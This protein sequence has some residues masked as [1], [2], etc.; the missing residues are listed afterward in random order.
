MSK[1]IKKD[2]PIAPDQALS[3]A[4]AFVTKHK[5]AFIIAILAIF[6][7]VGFNAFNEDATEKKE[8]TEAEA[9]IA[10]I[11]ATWQSMQPQAALDSFLEIIDLYNGTNAA[12]KAHFYAGIIYSQQENYEEAINHLSKYNGSD[13]IIAPKAK[14]LLGNCYSQIEDYDNAIRLILEAA[15][16]ANNVAVTPACWRDVAAMYEAQGKNDKAMNL[17]KKIKDEYP[18]SPVAN[19][20]KVKLNA[21]K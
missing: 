9:A 5:K 3:K 21:A 8:N 16:L 10:N 15:S 17:Y 18:Y 12:N 7:F 2:E 6:A 1:K 11:E 19:E 13:K 20:A 4:E 14:Q